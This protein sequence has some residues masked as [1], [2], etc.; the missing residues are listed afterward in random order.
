MKYLLVTVLRIDKDKNSVSL[1]VKYK[2]V[3]GSRIRTFRWKMEEKASFLINWNCG[4]QRKKKNAK[5]CS[6]DLWA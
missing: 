5:S 2:D 3:K 1:K 4:N 6:R